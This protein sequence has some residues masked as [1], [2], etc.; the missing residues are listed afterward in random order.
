MPRRTSPSAARVMAGGGVVEGWALFD[1][2]RGS[3]RAPVVVISSR[4]E[5]QSGPPWQTARSLK[6]AI[7]PQRSCVSEGQP[8]PWSSHQRLGADQ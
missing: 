2:E 6:V 7:G 8:G 4:C 3:A 5:G 1:T